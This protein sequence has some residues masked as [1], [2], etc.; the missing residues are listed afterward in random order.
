MTSKHLHEIPMSGRLHS[1]FTN[2]I[3]VFVLQVPWFF[4]RITKNVLRRPLCRVTQLI[5]S[6]GDQHDLVEA[7]V[8]CRPRSRHRNRSRYDQLMRRRYGRK[9]GQGDQQRRRS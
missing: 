4:I 3:I 5:R 9:A 7:Q 8:R 2:F 1:D 6:S